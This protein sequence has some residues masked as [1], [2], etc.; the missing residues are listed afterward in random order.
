MTKP[1]EELERE[2]EQ[3]RL[4]LNR[5]IDELSERIAPRNLAGEVMTMTKTSTSELAYKVLDQVKQNPGASALIGLGAA[6]LALGNSSARLPSFR[7]ED[8]HE[9]QGYPTTE[10]LEAHSQLTHVQ[11]AERGFSRYDS[12]DDTAFYGRLTSERGRVLGIERADDDDDTS[13]SQKVNERLDAIK[14]RAGI[15]QQKMRDSA[16]AGYARASNQASNVA[17][18]AR[19]GYDSLGSS[20]ASASQ[21]AQLKARQGYESLQ[22]S[23]KSASEMAKSTHDSH[24]IVTGALALAAG[25]LIGSLL[26]LSRTEEEKL[27]PVADTVAKHGAE[28]ASRLARHAEK[29]A[30]DTEDM[31]RKSA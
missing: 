9:F 16:A 22:Y 3:D 10:E 7:R 12:E 23:A 14:Y 21:A 24:P 28:G 26:P 20:A 25:A 18:A 30:K 17:Q 11:D 29:I 6:W 31:A 4:R 1:S 5:T 13:F 15:Y 2:L 8:T 27:R 19:S